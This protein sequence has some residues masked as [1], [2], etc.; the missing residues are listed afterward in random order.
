MTELELL[1]DGT[2]SW[3]EILANGSP[4]TDKL[5]VRDAEGHEIWLDE[6]ELAPPSFAVGGDSA[7]CPALDEGEASGSGTVVFDA[8]CYSFTLVAGDADAPEGIVTA[9]SPVIGTTPAATP[10]LLVFNTNGEQLATGTFPLS[11]DA[12]HGAEL[13]WSDATGAYSG[14]FGSGAVQITTIAHDYQAA[15]SSVELTFDVTLGDGHGAQLDLTGDLEACV[16]HF[17][18]GG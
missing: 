18:L 5:G 12:D 2:F 3:G 4:R 9:P 10:M 16:A 13:T 1:D 17:T 7:D 15:V 14:V 8:T 11:G 6:L